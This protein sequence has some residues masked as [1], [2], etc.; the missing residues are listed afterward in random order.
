[1]KLSKT[2]LIDNS[3]NYNLDFLNMFLDFLIEEGLEENLINKDYDLKNKFN[4]S[5]N[6][7]NVFNHK[8]K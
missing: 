8:S 3:A 1:M 5:I 7:S 4:S 6:K 2:V